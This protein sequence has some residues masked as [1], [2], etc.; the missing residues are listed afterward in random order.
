[1]RLLL[2]VWTLGLAGAAVA[3]VPGAPPLWSATPEDAEDEA[4]ALGKPVLLLW[5]AGPG[6]VAFTEGADRLFSSW[7]TWT[8]Q[9]R[10]ALVTARGR[11]WEAALPASYPSLPPETSALV[12]WKPGTA[13]APRV[14]TNLP[15]PLD[16]SRA[17]ALLSGRTLPDPYTIEVAG[18]EWE[19]GGL[20][21]I[22]DGPGWSTEGPDG[23]ADWLEEGP[24]GTVVIVREAATGR[25]AAFPLEGDWSFLA[26]DEG[27]S[28]V[29]WNPVLVK[30]R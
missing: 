1:M 23:P 16:L 9:V 5:Q 29:E 10:L 4:R 27:Q 18:Y 15:L 12:L 13:E 24:L 30:R 21:R 8:D 6:A 14:W 11:Q 2:L 20:W 28:W 25:R 7:P 3:Q 19:S 17:V 22:G 26:E